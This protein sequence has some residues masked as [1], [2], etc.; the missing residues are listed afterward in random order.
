MSVSSR[1][2]DR[3]SAPEGDHRRDGDEHQHGEDESP[4][5]SLVGDRQ[6]LGVERLAAKAHIDAPRAGGRDHDRCQR[7]LRKEDHGDDRDRQRADP[8][9]PGRLDPEQPRLAAD[10]HALVKRPG[11]PPHALTQAAALAEEHD[12][13]GNDGNRDR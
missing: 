7:L 3:A 6:G 4:I 11:V 13:S 12:E 10:G 8:Q 2:S 1:E 5:A 9:P